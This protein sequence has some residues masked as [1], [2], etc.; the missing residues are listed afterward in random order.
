MSKD[1][2]ADVDRFGQ[3]I[4]CGGLSFHLS[5]DDLYA[6]VGAEIWGGPEHLHRIAPGVCPVRHCGLDAVEAEEGVT[7]FLVEIEA[8]IRELLADSPSLALTYDLDTQTWHPEWVALDRTGWPCVRIP[9]P[10]DQTAELAELLEGED[11]A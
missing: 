11:E 10:D 3:L 7:H 5:G 9:M 8:M 2:D 6:Y 1:S 4:I